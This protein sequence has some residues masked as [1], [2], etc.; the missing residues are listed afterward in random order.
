MRIR[1]TDKALLM[2]DDADPSLDVAYVA[3]SKDAVLW[4]DSVESALQHIARSC[5]QIINVGRVSIWESA[6]DRSALSCLTLYLATTDAFQQGLQ[7]EADDFPH[8]FSALTQARVIDAYDA[9]HDPRT[10]EFAAGYLQPL[11]IT[12]MLDAGLRVGGHDVGVLCIE[13][14]GD[15]P[16]I[17]TRDEQIFAISMA[18]L[19]VQVQSFHSL[20]ASEADLLAAH[21]LLQVQNQGLNLINQLSRRLHAKNTPEEVAQDAIASLQNMTQAA[22]LVL[23]LADGT[24][25]RLKLTAHAGFDS[26]LIKMNSVLFMDDPLVSLAMAQQQITYTRNLDTAQVHTLTPFMQHMRSLGIISSTAIPLTYGNQPLGVV[27]MLYALPAYPDAVPQDVLTI[28]GKT[29]S[30]ALVNA[31]NIS[32]LAY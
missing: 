18:E 22:M 5:A 1:P 32:S 24:E 7:L 8:Y 4:G 28:F 19:I 13:H 16:R 2:R 26:A 15:T 17:W 23:Y 27:V 31:R 10:F 21:R 3:L 30:L 25:T 12:A 29:V 20:R 14:V 6:T 9:V 11:G